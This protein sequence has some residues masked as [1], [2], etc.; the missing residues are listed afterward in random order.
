MGLGV[1]RGLGEVE[2]R[3]SVGADDELEFGISEGGLGICQNR[4]DKGGK[5]HGRRSELLMIRPIKKTKNLTGNF[6]SVHTNDDLTPPFTAPPTSY[7]RSKIEPYLAQK[8]RKT[9][10]YRFNP[11][12]PNPNPSPH[13]SS[14]SKTSKKK[15]YDPNPL[16]TT[17]SQILKYFQIHK[18]D[19]SQAKTPK[20]DSPNG[21]KSM[22]S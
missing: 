5:F 19:T 3:G 6:E 21:Q 9:P 7:R 20:K 13:P 14:P 12:N 2:E 15:P 22:D 16:L 17:K 8:V 11:P 1:G 4:I 10:K 18:I